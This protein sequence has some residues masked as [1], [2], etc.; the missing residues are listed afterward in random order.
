[1]PQADATP[2]SP[3][4]PVTY[5]RGSLARQWNIIFWGTVATLALVLVVSAVLKPFYP[6]QFIYLARNLVQGRLSVD[7]LPRDL[8]DYALWQ[9]HVYVA[10]GP[11]PALVM[12]PFL[13]LLNAGL[14]PGWIGILTTAVN[15]WLFYLILGRLGF[16]EDKKRWVSLMF[17]G[18]TVYFA[19]S[20][21]MLA[22]YYAHV[23]GIT[24]ILWSILETLG[25]R[26]PLLIGLLLGLATAT[27]TTLIFAL[28]FCLVFFWPVSR[29]IQPENPASSLPEQGDDAGV[30]RPSWP[31]HLAS[32]ALLGLGLAIPAGLLLWYNYA[33][34]GSWFETGY[35][36]DVLGSPDLVIYRQ[37]G[38]FALSH[39]PMNLYYLFIQGPVPYPS[40]ESPLYT[41]PYLQP[42]PMGMAVFFTSPALLY[43]F[44]TKWKEPVV[45]ACLLAIAAILVPLLTYYATGWITFGDRY[46][47]DLMPFLVLAAAYGLP[48]QLNNRSRALIMLSVM[49]NL[50][51][52]YWLHGWLYHPAA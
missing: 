29:W 47:L 31:R 43:V 20:A 3:G 7:D 28:P 48:E 33:R 30:S 11:L 15:I 37:T 22:W 35:G 6:Q 27:R 17:F 21:T 36:F 19:M 18:G 52:T 42:S 49:I 24:L 26:R 51:G 13:P 14:L 46:T 9:G 5:R 8:Q 39:I 4:S 32:L 10:L 16:S 12:I 40:L 2:Q 38:L 23:I 45:R 34:F 44:R 25:R 41:F 50:W 1:M